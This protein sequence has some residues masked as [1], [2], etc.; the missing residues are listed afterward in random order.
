MKKG[1]T[2]LLVLLLSLSLLAV[3]C[4]SQK[5]SKEDQA[6][7]QSEVALDQ[8][9][10][11]E[12]VTIK[13]WE[14]Y[15][16]ETTEKTLKE[17]VKKFE[18][19]Y[20]NIKVKLTHMGIE[21]LRENTQTA[22]MGGKGPSVTI[23]PF[24]QAGVFAEMGIAQPLNDLIS[25]EMKDMY[26]DN[27][28]KSMKLN[29]NIYGI[30]HSMGNHLMLMYNKNLVD[31]APETWEELIKVAKEHTVDEDGDGKFDKYGFV[32]NIQEPFF[33]APF[34]TGFGGEFFDSN[35]K[36]S[37]NNEA[38]KDAMQF[39]R[40]LKFEHKV[41]PKGCDYNLADSLFKKGKAP[42]IM[43]GVW[44]INSYADAENVDL[45]IASLPKFKKTGKRAQPLTSGKGFIM[46]NDLPREQKIASLKFIKYM[47]SK[48]VEKVFV[49]RHSLLPSNKEVFDM[50]VI[51]EDE[52][53]KASAEQLRNGTPMPII[54]EMRG[55]WD[56]IKPVQQSV[57]SGD[58]D[59]ADAP[60]EM[61]KKAE[62]NVKDMQ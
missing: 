20:P 1:F 50:P 39:I 19:K 2:L 47:T 59:P 22:Y 28:L 27:A 34:Y 24:D 48:D 35:Q 10:L 37:L 46:V 8:E 32:F 6:E 9:E 7:Q 29:G 41:I 58:L 25:Q 14:P 57:M 26:T 33:W 11:E 31:E 21:D 15:N 4:S 43:N 54:A 36:P 13:V 17:Y 38:S 51:Q 45:G 23:S 53:L 56:G 61:Q 60:A 18:E 52:L 3:G 62:K 49:E 42:F 55:V 12:E 5:A 44:S 40:D 30:P 16:V